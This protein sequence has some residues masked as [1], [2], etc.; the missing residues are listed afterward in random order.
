[1]L[2]ISGLVKSYG[3]VPALRGVDLR[4]E[5][6]EVVGLLG[7]NGAGKTTLVSIVAGLRRPDAG[8]V[9]VLGVDAAAEPRATRRYLGIAPQ[10]LGLYPLQSVRENLTYLGE[11]AGLRR[12]V[13]TARV[14]EV[15][16][17]LRLTDLLDR[18]VRTLSGGEKRRVHTAMALVHRPEVLILDE[19]TT[20]V[21]VGTRTDVLEAV[22]T[23]AAEGSAVCYATHYLAEVETLR[24][25]VAILDHGRLIAR[26]DLD[27]LVDTYGHTVVVLAFE[28]RP[29]E[30]TLPERVERTGDGLRITTDVPA[31]T[32]ARALQALG[33][34]EARLT[35][36]EIVRPSL[37]S[38]FLTLTG[39]R[40]DA[41]D[42]EADAPPGDGEQSGPSAA[43]KEAV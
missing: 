42:A 8:S 11:L 5:P 37:E 1:M 7:P 13:L 29:P 18:R 15:A 12:R 38:V 43:A 3:A 24:A 31:T 22:R 39:R 6:G 32:V 23:L 27:T 35:G 10:E 9:R 26:D 30:L 34:D 20:G 33:D 25:T 41:G 14:A 2:E 16:E 4:I 36:L 19:P 28:G 21:D 17:R 40:Y